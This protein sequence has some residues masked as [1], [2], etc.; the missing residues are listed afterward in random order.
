MG[1]KLEKVVPWGRS[2]DEYIRMFNLTPDDL[3]LRIL[4]CAAGPASFNAEMTGKGYRVISCDPIYQFTGEEI[5]RRIEETYPAI[6]A[7]VEA[8]QDSYV[9]Q[10]I[11]SPAHL[12]QVRMAAM[13]QFLLDFSAGLQTG[14]YVLGELPV[15]PFKTGEFDLALCSHLLFTYSDHLSQTFHIEAITQLCRVASEVRIFPILNLSGEVSPLLKPAICELKSQGYDLEIQQ[16]PYEFQRGGHQLLRVV[17]PH[18]SALSPEEASY[19]LT[20]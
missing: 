15:L 2:L 11:Q 1:L 5:S 9:W 12:A 8:N 13:Q 3:R 7:G 19:N 10:D 4:D 17:H 16:V 18:L 6:M 20:I 14:R